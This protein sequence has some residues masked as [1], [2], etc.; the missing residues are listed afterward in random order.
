[1]A[2]GANEK[3]RA[4]RSGEQMRTAL[5]LLAVLALGGC[6]SLPNSRHWGEDATFRPGWERVGRSA[7]DAVRDPW[8][9]G[10][11]VGA[12]VLQIGN[13]DQEISDWARENTPVFGS[14]RSADRWSDDLRTASMIAYHASVLATP[15]GEE[16]GHWFEYKAKGYL[17]GFSAASV[18]NFTTKQLKTSV[19]RE[20]P[21]GLDHES[22]P[23][24][25]TSASAVFTQLASRNLRSIETRGHTRQALDIGLDALTIGT[26]WAR[27]EA[28]AHFP[29]DTLFSMA[30][31]NLLA[32]FFNDAFLGLTEDPRAGVA[33][34]ATGDGITLRYGLR[35]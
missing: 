23:S 28:G 3:T 16:P 32:S 24:G 15:S 7:L 13:A 20:R 1:M 33:V 4:V 31:G 27:I 17:V 12:G 9:W 22:F 26:A 18:T 34:V 21:S 6:A 25:H 8:V 35:F 11:L 5:A 19:D 10:P 29:S 2:D 30:L 14:E